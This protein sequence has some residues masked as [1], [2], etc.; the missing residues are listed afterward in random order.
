MPEY[1]VLVFGDTAVDLIIGGADVI[2]E[3]GQVEKLVERYTLELGGSCCIFASQAA[4]LGLKVGMLGKVGDDAFGQLVIDR[5]NAAGVDT[6]W[7][8]VDPALKTGLTIHLTTGHDRAMLTYLGSLNALTPADVTDDFLVAGRHLHYGSLYLHTGLLPAWLDILRRAK[9]HGLSLSLDT[10][11]DP[12]DRWGADLAEALPLLD[13][14]MPNEQEALRISG[15]RSME[16][17][18]AWLR[19]RVRLTALKQGADGATVYMGE[20][21]IHR[22]VEP[23][24]PGGDGIGAGDSFDAGF[25]AGWLRSLIIAESLEIACACGR[26]VAG[27]VGGVQGQPRMD[28]IPLLRRF[29]GSFI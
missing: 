10:N 3:F 12:A 4:K 2:P 18:A 8:V 21:V 13:V 7:M 5:L 9:A 28:D 23:A 22:A 6:R 20:Q 15:A 1:D 17:A 24:A 29:T 11:W 25:L 14:F 19:E 27:Q 26:A 16:G